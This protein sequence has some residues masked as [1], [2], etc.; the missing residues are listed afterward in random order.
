MNAKILVVDDE[1]SLSKL[2]LQ[3]FRKNIRAE[4]LEFIF[5]QNGVEALQIL[6][7]DS[8]V[9]M[10]MTDINMP[11]MDGLTL[12]ENIQNSYPRLKTIVVSAYEDLKNFKAAMKLGAADF[13]T[14]PIDFKE[15]E[16]CIYRTLAAVET[17]QEKDRQIES[18]QEQLK[19]GESS[20]TLKMLSEMVL[21]LESHLKLTQAGVS[22]LI[23]L[24][25]R[26]RN[27]DEHN[28]GDLIDYLKVNDLQ[29]VAESLPQYL[30]RMAVELEQ[31]G[32]CG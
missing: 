8:E 2:I 11:E 23:G 3:K 15:L 19:I 29:R 14:K 28:M 24:Y 27:L 4:E 32:G 21:S 7:V 22:A 26:C 1:I 18:L 17:E 5:A 16:Q 31:L 6:A 13:L 9:K 20:L 10:V 25:Q 12:L 30:E